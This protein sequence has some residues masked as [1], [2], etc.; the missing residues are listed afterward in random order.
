MKIFYSPICLTYSQPGHPES[1][2]RVQYTYEY[3]EEQ[4]YTFQEPQ[5]C[6]ETDILLAHTRQLIE[7]VQHENFFDFDTPVFSGIY[8]I[9]RLSAGAA[10]DAARASLNGEMAFS[11]MRPPGHH[12]T[13]NRLG[14]FC[15]FNNIAIACL[16][17]L[18]DNER[19]RKIAVVDFDCHHG[20]GTED[21]LLGKG[22][23]LY[24]SLHQSPLFPGTG[25][26]STDNCINY[27][28]SASTTPGQFLATLE[29]G[30]EKVEEF[31]PDLLAVSAGFDSYKLDPITNLTLELSTYKTIGEMLSQ[32]RKP[33]FSVLEGGYSRDLPECVHNFLTG[34][35]T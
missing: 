29:K 1:P 28:L 9:A 15:Y 22:E 19:V 11:L 6:T 16:T 33:T 7:D 34:M 17:A 13:R 10:V 8:D 35:E 3:L 23:A 26:K 21:I 18:R 5:P 30:L 14:G 31:D 32:L 2:A 27:P 12:A 25:Q 20:N 4:G 24:L